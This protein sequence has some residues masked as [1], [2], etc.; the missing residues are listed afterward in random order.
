V[1]ALGLEMIDYGSSS[2]QLKTM[3][4]PQMYTKSELS[5]VK[6]DQLTALKLYWYDELDCLLVTHKLQNF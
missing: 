2:F 5:G 4:S 6:S 1:Y 3:V